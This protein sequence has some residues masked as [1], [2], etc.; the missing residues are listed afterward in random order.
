MFSLSWV[1][2]LLLSGS[3]PAPAPVPENQSSEK[4]PPGAKVTALEAWPGPINLANKFSY[5]QVLINAKLSTGDT[6]DATRMAKFVL[7][8]Q[9]KMNDHGLVRP[10]AAGEGAIVATFEGQTV[11]IPVKVGDLSKP[12]PINFVRDV[13]PVISKTGCNAGTC[14]GA[15]DGKNGFKLSLRGYDLLEDHRSLTDDLEGRRFN[16]AAPD[17]SLMLLKT[18]GA[19]PHV[20]GVVCQPGEPNYEI[21]RAWIADGVKLDLNVPR[22]TS[23]EVFPKQF[24]APLPGMRQ[25]LSV[26]ASYTDGSKRD[27]T[28]ESFL[29]SSNIESAAIDKQG[30]V[31]SLRRGEATVLVRYEGAYAASSFICMGDRG[32]FAWKDQ[33]VNNFIDGLVYDKL[34]KIKVLPSELCTDEEFVRRIYLDLTG[35]PP[36]P[37]NLR[38]F[39][40]DPRPSREKRDALIDKLVGSPEFLENWTNKWADM[41][42]V[43]RKF[44]GDNGAKSL[45]KWIHDALADNIPYDRF[46]HAILTG[47]GSTLDQPA[48]AYYKILRDPPAAMENTTQLFLAIR[49]NCN[50][51]H[52]HPFERWTQ[53]QY[54]H[55]AAYFSQ[56]D[57]QEDPR[58]K[59]Q[60]VGGTDV[61]GAKPLVELVVDTNAGEVKHDRTGQVT[62]PQ[63]PYQHEEMPSAKANRREQLSRWLVSAKNPYFAKS[64]VNRLWA[65]LLGVGI[66]E[67]IDDIRAGNPPTNPALLDK[68]T[69]EFIDS[70]FNTRHMFRVICK[71]RA[72]QLSV[73]T[74]ATNKD[75]EINYSHALAR[76]LSAEVLFD[77]IHRV[78]GASSQLPGMAP[79]ARAAEMVDSTQDVGGGF[80][81]LFGRPPRESACECERSTGMMLGPVLNLVNGPV[82]GDA[83]RDPN[84]RLS[85]LLAS[86]Q[87]NRK[88]IEEAYLAILCRKPSEKEIAAGLKAIEEGKPDFQSMVQEK[89]RKVAAFEAI[90]KTVDGRQGDW[91]K[92]VRNTAMW[93]TAEVA[94]VTSAGKAEFKVQGDGSWL[95]S[96]PNPDKDEVTIDVKLPAGQ[97][98]GMRFEV[99]SHP[100]LGGKGP[101]RAGNGNFVLHELKAAAKVE[102]KPPVNVAL[103]R[104]EAD[105]AQ[106]SYPIE[107]AVDNNPGTGWAVA[108][109]TGKDHVAWFQFGQPLVLDKP[110]V[111]TLTM[112]QNYGSMHT[113]GRFRVGL[114]SAPMPLLYRG[115]PEAIVKILTTEPAKRT[116]AQKNEIA[117]FHRALEPNY[118]RLANEMNAFLVPA[119][120]RAPGLQDLAWALLNSKGFQFNH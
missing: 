31:T 11:R 4:L 94:K 98:T 51:C 73:N 39:L 8:A 23:I 33:P 95:A 3:S 44:L 57:R 101:G 20:G 89:A 81:Q 103:T 76:R 117:A 9:V 87:D 108:P 52:D 41:L 109:E 83:V 7:P 102:G 97:Y 82:I 47:K 69:E 58:Y 113:I 38:A 21:L 29:E 49:F 28:A 53:D 26:V 112:T 34:K 59:G 111:V 12:V 105:F 2:L 84:N 70:G 40:A 75:D 72:Y 19:V 116:D 54:Y 88:V 48:A 16:R 1:S 27:V 62:P 110:A 22:V 43:N 85:K 37:E 14:H 17:T 6:V 119:D 25:Q 5:S 77:T 71:S 79:G 60:K 114:T 24:V 55:L 118:A 78:M 104:P 96:G 56:I 65:Y 45:R 93:K 61:E 63:F 66:I 32:G 91:E 100:S 92:S 107:H 86:Q 67:P 30:L 120:P 18:S 35:L 15:K 42:Q 90:Q 106:G 50:K 46:V 80:F 115:P 64:Y 68:L 99:L 10:V 13:M 74:N 36:Q